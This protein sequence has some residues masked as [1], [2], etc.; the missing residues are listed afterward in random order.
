MLVSGS[1]A[2]LNCQDWR[3][4]HLVSHTGC[5]TGAFEENILFFCVMGWISKSIKSCMCSKSDNADIKSKKVNKTQSDICQ[6]C[7][8]ESVQDEHL[9]LVNYVLCLYLNYTEIFVYLVEKKV[10]NFWTIAAIKYW[11]PERHE[12]VMFV[13]C[14]KTWLYQLFWPLTRKINYYVRAHCFCSS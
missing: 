2:I 5:D 8:L 14:H 3:T 1:V 13:W 10:N 7:K 11:E 12:I 4:H 9:K 6:F